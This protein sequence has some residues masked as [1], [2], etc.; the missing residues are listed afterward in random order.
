MSF[1]VSCRGSG[2][3]RYLA[4]RKLMPDYD[5]LVVTA[6]RHTAVMAPAEQL[7]WDP[8]YFALEVTAQSA[9]DSMFGSDL[10]STDFEVFEEEFPFSPFTVEVIHLFDLLDGYP[11]AERPQIVKGFK[12]LW[13]TDAP[14]DVTN[15]K[16]HCDSRLQ[17]P[18][19]VFQQ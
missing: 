8:T 18:G 5:S 2:C 19:L 13:K 7:I 11:V 12:K 6:K 14:Q 10:S 15:E 9:L 17:T 1:A 16:W 3:G 4:A